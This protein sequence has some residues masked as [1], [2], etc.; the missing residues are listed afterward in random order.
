M[1]ITITK[2]GPYV[3]SGDVPLNQARIEQDADG[4]SIAWGK[5]KTYETGE[6]YAL[7]RCGHSKNKPF[8]DG[9][10]ASIGFDGTETASRELYAEAVKIYGGGTIDMMDRREL[11]Q[12]ARFCDVINAWQEAMK[13]SEAHPEHEEVATREACNCPSGRLTV[14]KDGVEIEY[15]LPQEISLVEDLYYDVKGPLFVKGGI[16]LVGAD[17]T[18][19]EVRNRRTLC[20]CGASLN[21]PFCDSTHLRCEH[22]KGLDE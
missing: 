21:L 16:T 22:M 8:C 12:V 14:R 2:D 11:C 15:D 13:S 9:T 3:V 7:C 6:T 10:H 20:R 19:Y 17:G 4:N 18:E 1:K 5:G